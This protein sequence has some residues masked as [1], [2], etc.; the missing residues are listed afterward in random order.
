MTTKFNFKKIFNLYRRIYLLLSE[1]DKRVLYLIMFNQVIIGVIPSLRVILIQYIL[2]GIQKPSISLSK[3]FVLVIAYITMEICND[4][5]NKIIS[6]ITFKF[7]NKATLKLNLLVLNKTSEL[8][9]KNF[10]NTDVYNMIQRAQSQADESV[11]TYF[12]SVIS[13]V[14]S[15]IT[16]ATNIG[17]LLAWRWWLLVIIVFISTF[18][19]IVMIHYSKKQYELIR[20]RTTEERKKWYYQFLLTNDLA[21]KEIK[22]YKLFDY[23]IKQFKIIYNKFFD[24][25]RKNYKSMSISDGVIT[26]IDDLCL[27]GIFVL[28]ILDAKYG[29]IMIGDAIAYITSISNIK[30]SIELF[31]GK[32]V[33]VVQQTLYISQI[34]EFIDMKVDSNNDNDKKITINKINSIKIENLSYKYENSNHYVLK[35]INLTLLDGD[36]VSLVGKNGSGKSTL[37]K[38]IAGFY[39]DY[40]GN[41]FVNDINLRLIDIES[42]Q[43][44]I[45]IFF[46]DYSKYE[47][48]L[49]ENVAIGNLEDINSDKKIKKALSLTGMDKVF[50]LE[51]QLGYWFENGTQLSGGQWIKIALS[52]TF[53]RN[54]DFYIL[55]EP[56][57]SLDGI[58]E[59]EI[60]ENYKLLVGKKIGLIVT[61]RLSSARFLSNKIVLLDKGEIIS[62]GNHDELLEK[63]TV[64]KGMYDPEYLRSTKSS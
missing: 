6:Y 21:F 42:Y 7:K 62:I 23:F 35:N 29:R 41:I 13:L 31:S 10:E 26:L 33:E 16:L 50:S 34:F 30:S 4:S 18:K 61:H 8:N 20:N 3:V 56:N 53:M 11:F 48:S 1:I 25:D 19:T 46:Q 45:G 60:L 5:I 15:I 40:E 55:D 63:S 59:K 39:D 54:S 43:K 64:Y 37:V 57:A 24:Q 27:G 14:S 47:L 32:F 58:S 2:N 52:R 49:R 51:T 17:I 12:M 36:I 22:M 38:I 44:V 28:S 9:L